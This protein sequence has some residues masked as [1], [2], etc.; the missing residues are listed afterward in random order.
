MNKVSWRRKKYWAENPHGPPYTH[1]KSLGWAD[2]LLYSVMAFLP[3]AMS[4]MRMNGA[5]I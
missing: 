5:R 2:S 4:F 1:A 3:Q